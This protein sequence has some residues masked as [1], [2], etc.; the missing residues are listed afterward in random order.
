MQPIS[1]EEYA[2]LP[3][4][5]LAERI[6]RFFQE[7]ELNRYGHQIPINRVLAI[8]ICK[9]LTLQNLSEP[10]RKRALSFFFRSQFQTALCS[11]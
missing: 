9:S 11:Q 5:E 8:E 1:H 2:H 4:I 6:D 10:D 3:S 7:D